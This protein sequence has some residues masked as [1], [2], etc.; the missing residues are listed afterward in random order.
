MERPGFRRL[1]RSLGCPGCPIGMGRRPLVAVRALAAG[2]PLVPDGAFVA[3]RALV[4]GRPFR[5]RRPALA[6][7]DRHLEVEASLALAGV[8][9]AQDSP[10][11]RIAT[12]DHAAV[13][14]N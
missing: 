7:A 3:V 14:G 13:A 5:A 4:A 10:E 1:W 8:D 6:P 11:L 12:L 9:H 2:R